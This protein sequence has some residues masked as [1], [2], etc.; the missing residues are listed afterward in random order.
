MMAAGTR[1]RRVPRGRQSGVASIE[2]VLVFPVLLLLFFGLVNFAHYIN[3]SLK[4]AQ[5]AV[6][7][8]DVVT[9]T[10]GSK[11]Q[12]A[13]F[14]DAFTAVE[15]AMTPLPATNIRIDFY[16]Y[17]IPTGSS[18]PTLRWRKSSPNGQDCTPPNPSVSPI[19]QILTPSAPTPATDVIVAV[20]C[21]PYAAPVP[22]FPGL[23][24]IFAN[25]VIRR[26]MALRPRNSTTLTCTAC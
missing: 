24:E 5:A 16:D 8:T 14:T 4:I 17:Y 2:F 12:A 18:V 19:I 15:L 22:N 11:V 21:M 10:V 26:S 25:I 9:R 7:A 1:Q 23:T 20:V 3:A 13:D 6:L